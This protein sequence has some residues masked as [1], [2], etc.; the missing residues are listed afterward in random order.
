MSSSNLGE[1]ARHSS[2]GV[3]PQLLVS[4]HSG[5]LCGRLIYSTIL[6]LLV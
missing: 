1:G 4:P 5:G 6:L 2:S 3:R